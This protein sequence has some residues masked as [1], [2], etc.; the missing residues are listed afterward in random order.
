MTFVSR[1]VD[2]EV[3]SD[4]SELLTLRCAASLDLKLVADGL[5][6]QTITNLKRGWASSL[7]GRAFTLYQVLATKFDI[8]VFSVGRAEKC[9]IS[10]H[11]DRGDA[12]KLKIVN[13][14][15]IMW[16]L[17]NPGEDQRHDDWR[18]RHSVY[19]EEGHRPEWRQLTAYR[20]Q[21]LDIR[22]L[23]HMMEVNNIFD[24]VPKENV[25]NAIRALE[26]G[27]SIDISPWL[28]RKS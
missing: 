1:L 26:T 18:W 12:Y 25:L 23:C 4:V 9:V 6:S 11:R 3:R 15:R 20:P 8:P 10:Y 14:L 17:A 22:A 19:D 5:K 13:D 27:E 24:V 16:K 28:R 7:T 21:I 2:I